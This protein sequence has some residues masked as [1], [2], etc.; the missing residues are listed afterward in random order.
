MY[1]GTLINELLS[2]VERVWDSTM[3]ANNSRAGAEKRSSEPEEF[4]QALGLSAADGNLGLLLVVHP[5]L[6]RAFEPGDHL[7]DAVDVNEVGAVSTP[8]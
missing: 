1:T 2:A 7:A 5:K 6:V 3:L 4:A 8:K